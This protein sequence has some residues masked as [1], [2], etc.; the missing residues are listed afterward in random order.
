MAA[1]PG[2]GQVM[3]RMTPSTGSASITAEAE[4][5]CRRKT[6]WLPALPTSAKRLVG[7]TPSPNHVL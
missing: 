7:R 6:A 1:N 2:G 5:R 3:I 4:P